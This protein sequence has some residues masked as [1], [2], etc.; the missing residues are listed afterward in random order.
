V[1]IDKK[2]WVRVKLTIEVVGKDYVIA[3]LL[4]HLARYICTVPRSDYSW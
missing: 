1:G 3:S 2:M 4:D